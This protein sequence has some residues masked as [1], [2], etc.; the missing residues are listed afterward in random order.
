W[1]LTSRGTGVPEARGG[2]AA[3]WTGTEMVVWGGGLSTGSRYCA[4]PNGR[5]VHRDADGDG[6]GN[7]TV[8]APT[9]DGSIPAG[10]VSD[11][12]DCNDV[13][14]DVHPGTADTNCNGVDENCDGTADEGYTSV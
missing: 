2:H 7:P 5:V 6:Y 11:N 13:R 12:T 4:C 1:M 9:C 8:T 10:Y 3:V 14:A